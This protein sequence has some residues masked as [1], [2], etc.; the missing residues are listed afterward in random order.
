MT[1]AKHT[2]VAEKA[3][4]STAQLFDNAIASLDKGNASI[5]LIWATQLVAA[6][7]NQSEFD[8]RTRTNA[9]LSAIIQASTARSLESVLRSGETFKAQEHDLKVILGAAEQLVAFAHANDRG[10]SLV[11]G[12]TLIA[13]SSA[14]LL[15]LADKSERHLTTIASDLD[16]FVN[17][18]W[19]IA[20]GARSFA[21]D[22]HAFQVLPPTRRVKLSA[23]ALSNARYSLCFWFSRSL[24]DWSKALVYCHQ[25]K[26]N[27]LPGLEI[28][29]V[30]SAT[31]SIDTAIAA[32]KAKDYRTSV[33]ALAAAEKT[34]SN[35]TWKHDD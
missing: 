4:F 5:A 13:R 32:L 8:E 7:S 17:E 2:K 11:I 9:L 33:K 29:H 34:M 35:Y 15:M 18:L 27:L 12:R 23:T 24:S 14:L 25:V 6:F 19:A 10:M 16:I 3:V 31:K 1:E 21:A 20:D 26:T 28:Y 22:P 30:A